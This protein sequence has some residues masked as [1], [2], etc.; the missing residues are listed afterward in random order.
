MVLASSRIRALAY[1]LLLAIVGAWLFLPGSN[2]IPVLRAWMVVVWGV[3]HVTPLGPYLPSADLSVAGA[4]ILT[5]TSAAIFPRAAMVA[6]RSYAFVRK[7]RKA[8]RARA[9]ALAA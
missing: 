6:W 9:K 5:M 2:A 4:S 3:L 8:A 7:R 1:V